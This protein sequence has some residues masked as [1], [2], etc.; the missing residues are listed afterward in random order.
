MDWK[1]FNIF[2]RDICLMLVIFIVNYQ[3]NFQSWWGAFLTGAMVVL[4]SWHFEECKKQYGVVR[5]K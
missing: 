4:T 3:S 5:L 1:W 2:M